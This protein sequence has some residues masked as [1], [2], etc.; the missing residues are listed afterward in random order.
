[1]TRRRSL[2]DR[3]FVDRPAGD[4][5]LATS[6]A[7]DVAARRGWPAPTLLRVGMNVLFESGDVVIRVSAPTA[8][9][10]A[11]IDLADMLRSRGIPVPEPVDIAVVG[12]VGDARDG[13]ASGLGA[14][15][16]R[17]VA[18]TTD[19][20]D[21]SAVGDVVRR[22]HEIPQA[23]IPDGYPVADPRR[24]PWWDFDAMLA[25]VDDLIDGVARRGLDEVLEHH[26]D[27]RDRVA[28]ESVVCHGDVH[29]GNVLMTRDGPVLL[30]WD[31][32]CGAHP[33]WDHAMLAGY[34]LRW[35]GPPETYAE[36][37]DG[38]GRS[39]EGTA[40]LDAL[41]D[42]RDV[43][44]TL[45]RVRAGRSDPDARAEA[46]RRLEFYRGAKNPPLWRLQ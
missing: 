29:P 39:F 4:V 11:A 22:V 7:A 33:A 46:G 43:A 14:S 6:V 17:R 23:G 18:A 5:A 13:W 12:G 34:A 40:L 45:M 15:A 44:A 2:A 26:A 37:L 9:A 10:H 32:M 1:M 19:P 36:F 31:L 16:W 25:E 24:F 21:W 35:G 41:R 28:A 3:P 8:P 27:W 38:Y 20:I 42:L 30:D